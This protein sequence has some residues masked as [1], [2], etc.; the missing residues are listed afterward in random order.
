M[1]Y[2]IENAGVIDTPALAIWPER[3][4][5]NISILKSFVKDVARLRPHVKTNKS[6]EACALMLEAGITKFKCATIAEAELLGE[7]GAPDVLLSYQPTGPKAVRLAQL[8]KHYPETRYSCLVDDEATAGHIAAAMT[9]AGCV[10]DVWI[11]LNIGMNRTGISPSA[12]ARLF[13]QCLSLNGIRPVGLHAYDGHLRDEDLSVRTRKC[14]EGFM[15]VTTLAETINATLGIRPLIVAGGSPTFPIHA[16]REGVECSPG[17]FIYWDTGYAS[18]LREQP[19]V[20]AAMVLT[21]VI[22]KPAPG[23]ICLDLGHKSIA[24]EN[25]L[26]RRV[27]FPEAPDLTPVGQSEEHL[28]MR[29]D[30]PDKYQV[31][32][33]LYGLPYHVCPTVALYDKAWAVRGGIATNDWNNTARR[34]SITI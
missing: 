21:R 7:A 24:S 2:T 19:F 22:S 6:P 26:D 23:V 32:Q 16:K 9:A 27:S 31:G 3:V 8:V 17:T 11:D 14:D 18:I 1:W 25:P 5:E 10:L 15:A 28:V 12:G 30:T 34:R 4:K 20:F 33:L 13:E 29:T